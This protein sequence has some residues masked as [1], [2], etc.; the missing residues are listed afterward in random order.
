MGNM[1]TMGPVRAPAFFRATCRFDYQPDV[2]KDYKDTGFCGFGDSCKFMH[3]RG[4][5]KTGWQME[6]E[7]EVEQ[8]KIAKEKREVIKAEKAKPGEWLPDAGWLN[9]IAL[10][11]A[12]AASARR[13][14]SRRTLPSVC[15]P[16]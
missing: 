6:K 4:N 11:R 14:S 13:G 8:I 2:C 9:I 5:Y 3:D 12:R 7:W 15:S 16:T 10:S 1:G